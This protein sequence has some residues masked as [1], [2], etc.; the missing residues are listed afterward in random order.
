[1][2]PQDRPNGSRVKERLLD[3]AAVFGFLI[4]IAVFH[5]RLWQVFELYNWFDLVS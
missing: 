4:L 2:N 1:M 3:V 5:G